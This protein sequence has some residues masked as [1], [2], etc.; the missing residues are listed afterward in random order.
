LFK[1]F[2]RT[3]NPEGECLDEV[4]MRIDDFLNSIINEYTESDIILCISHGGV[5]QT[6]LPYILNDE[7]AIHLFL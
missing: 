3:G 4:V 7:N 2:I 5:L 1:K 6:T